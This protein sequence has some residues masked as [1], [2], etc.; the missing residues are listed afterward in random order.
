MGCNIHDWMLSY[1]YVYESQWFEAVDK[2]GKASFSGVAPGTYML[3]VWSPR[4]K[5]NRSILEEEI[6]VHDGENPA[7]EQRLKVRK[8]IRRKPRV[9]GDEYE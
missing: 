2:E 7:L 6:V 9:E 8:K 1:L 3:R 4:M 5:N